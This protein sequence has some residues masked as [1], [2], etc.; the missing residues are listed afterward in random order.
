VVDAIHG[1]VRL[2]HSDDDGLTLSTPTTVHHDRAEITH[3]FDTLAVD[4]H[5]RIVI[6]W[7]DKRDGIA[8]TAAGR[9]YL[10]AAIYYS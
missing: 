5:D 10:G 8:A 4:G 6:A 1:Q 3:R 7:I 9:P 2:R